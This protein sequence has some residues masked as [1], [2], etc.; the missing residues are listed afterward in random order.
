MY[1]RSLDL[2][3][4]R[5]LIKTRYYICIREAD[6][7]KNKIILTR[8]KGKYLVLVIDP[9]EETLI[10]ALPYQHFNLEHVDEFVRQFD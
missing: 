3:N 9:K 6:D 2:K 10:T 8:Y 4:I 7:S 1:I 5:K